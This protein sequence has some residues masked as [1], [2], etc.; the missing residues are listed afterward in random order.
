MS[1][2]SLPA[3]ILSFFMVGCKASNLAEVQN[4]LL[5]FNSSA[6]NALVYVVFSASS[7][8]NPSDWSFCAQ[9]GPLS[10]YF[11]IAANESQSL[12]TQNRHLNATMSFNA[13]VGCG[14]TKAEIN[15]NDPKWYDTLDISLVDGFNEPIQ[16]TYDG[17]TIGRVT[18]SVNNEKAF[19]VYPMGC[20]LCVAK[21]DQT[22]CG[23]T[24]GNYGCKSG[25]QYEPDV[26]CQYQ[27]KSMGGGSSN[28]ILTLLKTNP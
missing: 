24:P 21:S 14:S 28:V 3:V 13:P 6:S 8:V 1:K 10:C 17:Q 19:G 9:S 4:Q 26:P 20:D 12:P 5:V 22:P 16:L 25:T 15:I 18:D 7:D 23:M 2:L 27:G 11:T